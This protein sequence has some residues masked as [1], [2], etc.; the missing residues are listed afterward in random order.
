M[1]GTWDLDEPEI[2]FYVLESADKRDCYGM[3]NPQERR[4]VDPTWDPTLEIVELVIGASLVGIG[5]GEK[6]LTSK[7]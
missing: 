7:V 4:V 2:C 3:N 6:V 5:S 1:F